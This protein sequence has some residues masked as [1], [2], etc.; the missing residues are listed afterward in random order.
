MKMNSKENERRKMKSKKIEKKEDK[1]KGNL[2]YGESRNLSSWKSETEVA[3]TGRYSL[4]SPC[5]V[6]GAAL[7]HGCSGAISLDGT[8]KETIKATVM[9]GRVTERIP[10]RR[11]GNN[12]GDSNK[13]KQDEEYILMRE[14]E[15]E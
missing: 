9:A 12:G 2:R 5:G 14:G 15:G 4:A 13:E 10:T 3:G 8:S 1:H 6:A 7:H 11:R